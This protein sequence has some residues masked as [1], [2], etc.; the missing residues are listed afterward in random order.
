MPISLAVL[1]AGYWGP[2]LARNA[3][4]LEEIRLKWVCDLDLERARRVVGDQTSVRV[5]ADLDDV[6]SDESVEA[7][8]IATPPATHADLA[9]RCIEA[10]RH[11]LVEK[12]LAYSSAVGTRVV[13]AAS[14]RGVVLQCDH[15]FC[16]TPAVQHIH[17][18]VERGE[19]GALHYYDS[20]RINLGLVQ[21]DTDVFWDLAP[22]DISILDYVLGAARRPTV[23]MAQG[24]DPLGLGHPCLGYVSLTFDDGLLAHFHVSWLSPRKVR[25]T[26]VGGSERMVVWND[27]LPSQRLSVFDS[28]VVLAE[29]DMSLGEQR[30]R[31]IS[32]RIG[33]MYAPALPETEALRLVLQ[34]FASA[35]RTE[36]A[37]MTDGHS[38][39][40]LLRVI[41]AIQESVRAGG[42]PVALS[43][44]APD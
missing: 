6:L 22:H 33:D 18:M 29:G 28:G 3:M 14:R 19:L 12:P 42:T 37:P 5:T 21:A 26:I 10:G 34:E 24:A 7:V 27:L 13:E 17:D 35:I 41:E 1:G 31:Q 11:V 8:T 2:N 43:W 30:R 20:V 39:L 16:Y 44:P 4:A 36:R 25:M 40:R 38:G 32:Y 9:M 15:T 23:V